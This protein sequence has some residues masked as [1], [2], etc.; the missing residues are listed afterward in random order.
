MINDKKLIADSSARGENKPVVGGSY[1]IAKF[2]KETQ[3]LVGFLSQGKRRWLPALSTKNKRFVADKINAEKELKL[4]ESKY[5]WQSSHNYYY[6]LM[7]V[8]E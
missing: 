3:R 4:I 8:S 1:I 6:K 7:V 5:W 2:E